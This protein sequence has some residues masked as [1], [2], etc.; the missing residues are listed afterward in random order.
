[1]VVP[2]DELAES[3]ARTRVVPDEKVEQGP[4]TN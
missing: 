1:M 4:A 3:T 2:E